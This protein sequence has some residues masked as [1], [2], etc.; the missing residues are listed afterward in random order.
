MVIL[1]AV[2]R[3]LPG[4]L[5]HSESATQDSFSQTILD[6]P[7]YTRPEVF[8]GIAVPSVLQSGHHEAIK[9]YREQ[10]ALKLTQQLRPDLLKT[11][12]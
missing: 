1:D 9:Q 3:L 7:H 6:H 2:I 5:G 12:K 8:E 4:A 11:N 10:Q